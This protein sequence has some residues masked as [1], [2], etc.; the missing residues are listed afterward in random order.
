MRGDIYEKLMF[1]PQFRNNACLLFGMRKNFCCVCQQPGED[2]RLRSP[3]TRSSKLTRALA[4]PVLTCIFAALSCGGGKSKTPD[5]GSLSGNWQIGLAPSLPAS[6]TPT[7]SG[8]LLQDG[9]SLTGQFV[10][11]GQ[12]QCAGLG[13]AQGTV[14][15]GN[16]EITL[17]QTGQTVTLTGT[18]ASDGSTMGGTYAV[19]NSGC[20]SETST[21]TWSA[22]PVKPV[23]GTYLATFSSFSLGVYSFS[24]TV[25]Q[26]DNTGASI[27]TV[28]GTATSSN[29]P[30]GDN[31][32]VA[33]A[34]GGTSIVFN[35]LTS[36]GTAAGQFRGTTS[37]DGKA[38]NGTY[39]FVAQ[40]SN[41]ACVA[42]DSGS[43]T[44]VQQ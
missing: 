20:G 34:V 24:V 31:L 15:G 41:S 26:G 12:T 13:S 37:T 3:N 44:L 5:P 25:T 43:I 38:L 36:D 29:A 2:L 22:N 23:S 14:N 42:G 1:P 17:A 30:C 35:F 33:G 6:S 7:E 9:T 8:F 10:L 18:A 27:A 28:S 16:V 40:S 39:D 32:T 11:G 21:G 19:L 4:I